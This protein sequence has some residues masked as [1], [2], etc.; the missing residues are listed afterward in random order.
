MKEVQEIS[1]STDNT[2]EK[3][4]YTVENPTGIDSGK[5]HIQY[6]STKNS[7]T[8]MVKDIK[9]NSD[10]AAFK[11]KVEPFFRGYFGS[12]IYVELETFEKMNETTNL[13]WTHPDTGATLIVKHI[14]TVSVRRLQA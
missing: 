3:H 1:I 10:A 13:P 14:Y 5:Y 8:Y 12:Y 4:T 7:S 9:A 2:L 11:K 6:V